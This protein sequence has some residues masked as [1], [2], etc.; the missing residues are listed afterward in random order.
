MLTL[1]EK[2]RKT[3]EKLHKAKS[4]KERAI[5]LGSNLIRH[6]E[7]E[8]EKLRQEERD[9]MILL[10][11]FFAAYLKKIGI[12]CRM[13]SIKLDK[14]SEKE[15]QKI[16]AIAIK[17]GVVPAREGDF[18]DD[19][20]CLGD[21]IKDDPMIFQENIT[22]DDINIFIKTTEPTNDI[23]QKEQSQS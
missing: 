16:E 7:N 8:L 22:A 10:G 21:E 20:I 15:R 4:N 19:G 5:R 23:K 17:Y 6:Y 9:E 2:I 3:E 11:R 13:S 1:T 14:H 12:G 18:P